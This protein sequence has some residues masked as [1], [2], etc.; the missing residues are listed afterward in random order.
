M[1]I[2]DGLPSLILIGTSSDYFK[3]ARTQRR[4][5]YAQ[6]HYYSISDISIRFAIGCSD[7]ALW[8]CIFKG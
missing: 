8:V 7:E 4:A 6:M 1:A 3:A 2:A 5:G